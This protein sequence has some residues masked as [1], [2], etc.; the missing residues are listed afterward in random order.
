MKSSIVSFVCKRAIV[1]GL[2]CV[3][4]ISAAA[5]SYKPAELYFVNLSDDA[6]GSAHPIQS[7]AFKPVK[8]DSDDAAITV[9]L[10]EILQPKLS[11]IGGAFNE[12]GGGA[13]LSLP[14]DKQKAVVE[15]LF[16][17]E[18]GAGLTLCRTA[19]GSSDF[20]LSAYSYSETPDDYEMKYFSVAR[21]EK[22][23]IPFILAAQAEN[24]GLRIFASPWSPP[25]WMKESGKMDDG[26][27][28]KRK[29]NPLNVLKSDPEI[30]KAYALYFAKYVQGYAQNGVTIERILVQNETDMNPKY[31][32]CD[33]LPEQMGE[34]ISDYIRPAFKKTKLNAEIWAGTFRGKRQ[35]AKTFMALEQA[36][37]IDGVGMQYASAKDLDYLISTY[38]ELKLMHTEGKCWNGQNNMKQARSR[39]G[40]VAMW[41]NGGCENYCYWNMVLNEEGKSAWGWKQNCLIN[42]DRQTGAVTYNSDFVAMALLSRYIRPGDEL[43][44][45]ETEG[46]MPSIAVRNNDR[47]VVFLQNDDAEPVQRNIRIADKQMTVEIPAHQLCAF[48]FKK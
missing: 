47:L 30:Y 7:T 20:G 29:G 35:D 28:G 16:N 23:V 37:D 42:I 9:K 31:P 22:T 6:A 21:D 32:G 36:K 24:P 40:E 43:L 12:I 15:A 26:M 25:G 13:F 27:L 19:I 46:N 4:G 18:T 45:V 41:L 34:L 48:V 39:F 3:A 11:G 2:F 1:S 17:P 44:K 8:S 5:E 10:D 14:K 33:M 38:P